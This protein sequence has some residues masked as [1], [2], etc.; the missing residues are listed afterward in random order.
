MFLVVSDISLFIRK[1]EKQQIPVVGYKNKEM[2]INN[3]INIIKLSIKLW[4]IWGIACCVDILNY[5]SKLGDEYFIFY[6]LKT[7]KYVLLWNIVN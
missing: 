6:N 3:H 5:V 7:L 2:G 4:L 1:V